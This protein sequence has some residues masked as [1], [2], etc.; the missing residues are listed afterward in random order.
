[1]D[2]SINNSTCA[3]ATNSCPTFMDQN[4]LIFLTS[5]TQKQKNETTY[6]EVCD[7]FD[8]WT[9]DFGFGV[10]NNCRG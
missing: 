4:I 5:M 9:L 2:K 3:Y 6:E 8:Y 7:I 10:Y 1:M